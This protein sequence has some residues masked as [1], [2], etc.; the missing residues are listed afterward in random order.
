MLSFNPLE[1]GMGLGGV[2]EVSTLV[3][4]RHVSIRLNAAWVLGDM[5]SLKVKST[6]LVSIRLNAAWVLG[7]YEEELCEN[8][9][10]FQSA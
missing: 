10:R 5:R 3:S 4:C 7:G 1:R 9:L 8:I 2:H 6:V